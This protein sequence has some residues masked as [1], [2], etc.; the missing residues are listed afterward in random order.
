MSSAL[1][2][3]SPVSDT[4]V[5]RTEEP[6]SLG[7]PPL[8]ATSLPGCCGG[9]PG[10]PIPPRSQGAVGGSLATPSHLAPRVLCRAAWPPHPTRPLTEDLRLR[11]KAQGVAGPGLQ[12]ALLPCTPILGHL[13]PQAD[14]KHHVST[15]KGPESLGIRSTGDTPGRGLF[16]AVSLLYAG[17]WWPRCSP[18]NS[19]RNSKQNWAQEVKNTIPLSLGPPGHCARM[20]E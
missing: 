4:A 8:P 1:S 3:A 11:V 19:I 7:F 2:L 15:A 10:R 16:E 13:C 18:M 20:N 6:L 5:T 17:R 14:T 12:R 9:K